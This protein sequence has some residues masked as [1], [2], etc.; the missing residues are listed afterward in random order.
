MITAESPEITDLLKRVSEWP[1]QARAT[2]ARRI[3]ETVESPG[4]SP[5]RS[6]Y[7]ASE[8]IAALEMPQPAPDDAAVK[9]WVEDRRM[10]KY[11]Q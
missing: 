8:V 9:R 10:E 5:R 11:G 2:L 7:W 6:G 4:S 1:P 3:L